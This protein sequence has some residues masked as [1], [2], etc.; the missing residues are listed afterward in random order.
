MC[1]THMNIFTW[2][3]LS[4]GAFTFAHEVGGEENTNNDAINS[5][6]S[7]GP[8]SNLNAGCSSEHSCKTL[9]KAKVEEAHLIHTYS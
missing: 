5:I 9:R 1:R 8:Y 6:K 3:E 2:C 7:T 4:E